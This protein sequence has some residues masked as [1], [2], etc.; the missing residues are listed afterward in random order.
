MVLLISRVDI[1]IQEDFR[2]KTLLYIEAWK[3]D[4]AIV[5]VGLYKG[6]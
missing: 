6:M 3:E 4:D 2:G 1:P 5:G